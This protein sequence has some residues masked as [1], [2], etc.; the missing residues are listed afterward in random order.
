[1]LSKAIT[2]LNKINI[3]TYFKN[4]TIELHVFYVLNTHVKFCVNRILFTI[5]F[6][7]WVQ[8]TPGVTLSNV[9][10]PN[11]LLLNSYFKKSTIGLHILYVFNMHANFHAK[12]I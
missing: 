9:I 3:T 7:G 12:R 8:V 6:I 11:N 10:L 2:L 5:L 4:I 1:M